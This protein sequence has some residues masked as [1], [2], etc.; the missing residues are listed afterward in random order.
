VT[1]INPQRLEELKNLSTD[2]GLGNIVVI[3]GA[4]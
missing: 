3:E 4:P 2:I 1:D